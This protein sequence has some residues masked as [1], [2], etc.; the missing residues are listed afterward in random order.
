M[1]GQSSE[2]EATGNYDPNEDICKNC[3]QPKMPKLSV[4]DKP[5]SK[6]DN[7]D[8]QLKHYIEMHE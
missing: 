8:K 3:Y 5:A 6:V 4:F 2:E 1:P 7:Q